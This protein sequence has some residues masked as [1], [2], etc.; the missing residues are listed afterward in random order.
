M[1]TRRQ[2]MAQRAS[3]AL[4]KRNLHDTDT[5]SS[6]A[7]GFPALIHAAGL[8]QAVAFLQ[9]K[10]PDVLEDVIETI[11]EPVGVEAFARRCREEEVPVYM[12]LTRIALDGSTWIKRYVESHEKANDEEAASVPDHS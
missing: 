9:A 10:C 12:H 2:Q 8:C 1:H 3:T 4:R 5:Y 6:Y 11:G 7:K